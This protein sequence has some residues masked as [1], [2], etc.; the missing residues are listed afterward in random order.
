MLF[1]TVL[2]AAGA[3]TGLTAA[4][5]REYPFEVRETAGIRRRND[6]ITIR[7]PLPH[8]VEHAAGFRVLQDGKPVPAQIRRVAL[9]GEP[10]QLVVDFIDHFTP[11]AARR[12]VLQL[13]DEPTTGE[14]ADGLMLT[15]TED[16]YHIDSSGLVFWTIRK[17]LA[18]LLDFSWK[19]TTYIAADSAG[20]FF[21][22]A[23][24]A[25]QLL[26]DRAPSR[27]AIER[28]GPL[29]TS[30]VFDYDDWP[31]GAHSR[32]RLEFVRTKSWI[33]GSWPKAPS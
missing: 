5:H 26:A 22:G 7:S 27:V 17:E 4:D 28:Q 33:R 3:D 20:L 13:I 11:F 21:N 14:P 19:Q 25:R 10:P 8:V 2:S 30:L 31:Q 15:E 29:A 1:L 9:P 18:G 23:D 12:Y 24:G 32:V 6:V 16:A